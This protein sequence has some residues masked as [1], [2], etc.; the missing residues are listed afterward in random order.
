M[1]LRKMEKGIR[2]NYIHNYVLS[3]ENSLGKIK[4]YE[5]VSRNKNLSM[6]ELG[7]KKNAIS[8]VG[9]CDDKILLQREFRLSINRWIYTFPCGLIDDG[10]D[11]I[12]AAQRELKEETSMD[13]IETI[14]VLPSSF[15]A[16]GISDERTTTIFAK[17]DGVPQSNPTFVDEEIEPMLL[18]KNEVLELIEKEEF[19][20]KAQAIAYLWAIG[21]II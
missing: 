13:Y 15:S 16:M 14:K 4:E 21:G 9:F 3:Y 7:T 17:V 12:E 6:E 11:E 20:G 10:E 19:S 5:I 18:T 1:I 2:D 8:I